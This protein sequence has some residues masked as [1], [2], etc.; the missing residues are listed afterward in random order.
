[1]NK[2]K[3]NI[4]IIL[5]C[6]GTIFAGVVFFYW[7]APAYFAMRSDMKYMNFAFNNNPDAVLENKDFFS[8][9]N[10]MWPEV[11]YFF[12]NDYLCGTFANEKN[13]KDVPLLKFA[14]EK[15]KESIEYESN[16][17]DPVIILGKVYNILAVASPKENDE[18]LENAGKAY[19]KALSLY[20]D[21]QRTLYAYSV[22]FSNQGKD[23][24]ALVVAKRALTLDPR[25]LES[26]YYYAIMLFKKGGDK[27]FDESLKEFEMTFNGGFGAKDELPKMIYQKLLTYYYDKKNMENLQ[28]ILSRLVTLNSD[29]AKTYQEILG[30]IKENNIIPIINMQ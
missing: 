5:F 28:T 11:V 26:H 22:N 27:N 23:D 7:S 8:R 21:N 15:M 16:Y 14:I 6:A 10:Y 30:Y 1:M 25:V 9:K 2:N 19:E 20:K 18:M 29:E 12:V 4:F 13:Y 24:E 17:P 3:K